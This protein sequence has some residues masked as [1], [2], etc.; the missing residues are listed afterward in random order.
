MAGFNL[1]DVFRDVPP[2]VRKYGVIGWPLSHTLSPAMQNAAMKALNIKAVY[3]AI[4]VPPGELG[5]FASQAREASLGGF[6]VTVPYKEEIKN[7]GFLRLN[8]DDTVF[9]R[10]PSVNTMLNAGDGWS[11]FSTDGDGFLD[12]LAERSLD[13]TGQRV[14]LLGA[15]GACGAL[16]WAFLRRTSPGSLTVVNRTARRAE[17]LKRHFDEAAKSLKVV[18]LMTDV[19][20][21]REFKSHAVFKINVPVEQKA[22]RKALEEADVIINT[23]SVGLKE[24]DGAVIDPDFFKKSRKRLIVYDL[25]YHRKTA[26]LSAAEAAGAKVVDGLGMLV[27]QGARSFGIWFNR[28]PPIDQM[29]LAAQQDMKRRQTT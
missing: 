6:N 25:I 22:V 2:G 20:K 4:P 9:D 29:R 14:V 10:L 15:G 26:L 3:R 24:G 12:D 19:W 1:Q 16:L 21:L 7:A 13:L 5:S 17:D 28:R 23:T 8:L 27:H 11:G 18:R